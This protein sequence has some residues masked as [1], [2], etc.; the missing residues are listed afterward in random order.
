MAIRTALGAGRGARVS[1]AAGRGAGARGRR[2]RGRAAAGA[3][4]PVAPA[5]RCSPIR[6]RAPTK[7]RSTRRVLLFALGASMLT[8]D[9][10]RRAAGAPRRP[11]R[12]QRR[13]EG[14]RARATAP[15]ASRTRRLLIVCEVALSVVLLMGAGVMVR[16]LL[17][18][19]SVDAGFD[20]RNVLTMQRV[21][22]GGAVP[23][24]GADHRVLRQRRC[25]AFARCPACR[26]RRSIDDLPLARRIAAADRARGHA[27]SCCRAISRRS[28]SARSRPGYLR[29]MGDSAAA[30]PRRRRRRRRDACWSAARRRSCCGATSIRSAATRRCRSSRRRI[31]EHG[32]RHRRRRQA[33]GTS[34][35]RRSPTVYY[36]TRERDWS[37]LAF[38]HADVGAAAVAGPA[39]RRGDPRDRSGAA[40]RGHPDDGGGASTR[41]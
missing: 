36:Y 39:G 9:P 33:G 41:R 32:G 18:L 15:S 35:R 7:S 31:V 26:R 22:A 14:R 6:C 12:S 23:D 34:P 5:R 27:P 2:R 4:R 29:A 19:R 24:A 20:P 28:R 11:H 38:V 40:G 37:S 3:R 30:R 16:S 21:A 25:S 17:A 10:R 8:G 13:A 1:A